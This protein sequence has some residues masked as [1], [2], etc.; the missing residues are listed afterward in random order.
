DV[1]INIH[2]LPPC[3]GDPQWLEIAWNHLIANAIKFTQPR[4]V[5]TL[6][7]GAGMLEKTPFYFVRDNGIGFDMK[8]VD[9]IF[10]VFQRLHIEDEFEGTGMGLA[11]TSRIIEQHGGRIWANASVNQGA[12][13]FFTL[14]ES[15]T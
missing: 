8:Y 1:R 7:I 6:E 9:K 2:P 4:T 3:Q 11:L 15:E 13:F 5:A 12:T 10:G 14:N